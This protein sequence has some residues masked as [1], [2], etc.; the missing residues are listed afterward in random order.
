MVYWVMS[1]ENSLNIWF[2]MSHLFIERSALHAL[3]ESDKGAITVF[4]PPSSDYRD[5]ITQTV[6]VL[7]QQITK[8]VFAD[9]TKY[10]ITF[11]TIDD[12]SQQSTTSPV[13]KTA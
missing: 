11:T 8:L 4:T 5:E 13:R 10:T 1:V 2:R 9:Q 7:T 6:R 3:E 12:T